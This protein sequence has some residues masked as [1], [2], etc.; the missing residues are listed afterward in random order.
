[1]CGGVWFLYEEQDVTTT[2]HTHREEDNK[3]PQRAPA[4]SS[5]FAV[6][7][8]KR[9]GVFIVLNHMWNHYRLTQPINT[10]NVF[11]PF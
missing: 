8:W 7:E 6:L 10:E 4:F 3:R 1:M 9:M 11:V 5:V 2:I